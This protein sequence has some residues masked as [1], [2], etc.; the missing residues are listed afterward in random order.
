MNF[1]LVHTRLWVLILVTALVS[2][3]MRVH[4]FIREEVVLPRHD[5]GILGFRLHA[6]LEQTSLLEV[7]A[8]EEH[9][10]SHAGPLE[11]VDR[12]LGHLYRK[13]GGDH[14]P[15]VGELVE[16]EPADVRQAEDDGYDRVGASLS[17]QCVGDLAVLSCSP[18][19]VDGSL[20][21][22]EE[23]DHQ[24]RHHDDLAQETISDYVPCQA[25][26]GKGIPFIFFGASEHKVNDCKGN[27]CCGNDG[28]KH[29]SYNA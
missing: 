24:K 2:Q 6:L 4:F 5:G 3:A 27:T 13:M 18:F 28:K 10:H 15:T 26:V 9:Q 25:L 20:G 16:D 7:D 12:G 19:S 8:V 23:P 29:T 1:H 17:P 14:F 22:Y 11:Q 21:F